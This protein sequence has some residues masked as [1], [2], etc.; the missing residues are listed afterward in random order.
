MGKTDTETLEML[1]QI[2]QSTQWE[3]INYHAKQMTMP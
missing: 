1:E 2:S 3:D